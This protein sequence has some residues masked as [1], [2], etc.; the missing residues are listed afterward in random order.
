[1]AVVALGPR[2]ARRRDAGLD[3]APGRRASSSAGD[4]LLLH[5]ADH[6]SEPGLLAATAGALPLIL[7]AI[8]RRGLR[9][10]AL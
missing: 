9:S 10:A 2:L 1:M 3:R 8:E 4:V 6:Y 5:D 7:D